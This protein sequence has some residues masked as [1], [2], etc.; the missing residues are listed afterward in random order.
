MIKREIQQLLVA[1]AVTFCFESVAPAQTPFYS[2]NGTGGTGGGTSG[3]SLTPFIAPAG[4][5]SLT[6]LGASTQFSF[7][8]GPNG[9]AGESIVNAATGQ[10]GAGVL[11]GTLGASGSLNAFTLT[12]WVNLSTATP[13]NYRLFEI[14]PGAP[15][16]TATADGTKLFVG[17]NAGGGL[18]AYVNNV[19]GNTVGTDIATANTWNN[20]GTL[21]TYTANKWYF[22][23]L[24][25]DVTAGTSQLYSGDQGTAATLAYSFNN[26][27]GGALD[28]STDSSL[29]LLDRFSGGRNWPG[30][31]DDVNV[32]NGALNQSQIDTIQLASIPEPSPFALISLGFLGLVAIRRRRSTLV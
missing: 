14:S 5:S 22:V 31:I 6:D 19:N 17:L 11:G 13:N 4:S 29:S 27:S 16:S 32:Y 18:Q 20:G 23:A 12:L 28:L 2:V 10:A 21:G 7:G 25:Y 24:T 26:T 3:V 8:I 30:A 9:V 1:A 15:A